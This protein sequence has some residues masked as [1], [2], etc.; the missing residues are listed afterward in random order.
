M[1]S[2]ITGSIIFDTVKN[3]ERDYEFEE[4]ISPRKIV[5]ST[6]KKIS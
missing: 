1:G 3:K 6:S 5:G 4:M 2:K